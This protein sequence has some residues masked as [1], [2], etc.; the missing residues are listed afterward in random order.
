MLPI[1]LANENRTLE[2]A[3]DFPDYLGN[4]QNYVASRSALI[5]LPLRRTLVRSEQYGTRAP[6]E[7]S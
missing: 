5:E 1:Y 2:Q 3:F 7:K 4:S 6:I